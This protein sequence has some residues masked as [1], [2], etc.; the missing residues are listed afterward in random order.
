MAYKITI[1]KDKCIG[2]GTCVALC[3]KNFYL[4]NDGKARTKEDTT[5]S[6]DCNQ[7]AENNCPTEAISIN[8]E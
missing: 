8:E 5:N 6:L 1:D 2:C 7:D 3:P 4:G